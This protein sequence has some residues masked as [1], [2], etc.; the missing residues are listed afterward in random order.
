MPPQC[1]GRGKGVLLMPLT[2]GITIITLFVISEPARVQRS[3]CRQM[4]SQRSVFT[5]RAQPL[6]IVSKGTS[7]TSLRAAEFAAS[8]DDN[9]DDGS[10]SKH[11]PSVNMLALALKVWNDSAKGVGCC[12]RAPHVTR[13]RNCIHSGASQGQCASSFTGGRTSASVDRG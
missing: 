6:S 10:R 13:N 11:N 4:S 1:L 5:L 9:D 7:P 12:A 8:P 3:V 2:A